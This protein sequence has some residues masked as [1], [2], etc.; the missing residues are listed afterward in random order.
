MIGHLPLAVFLTLGMVV[1]LGACV[2]SV[3]GFGLAVVAAPFVVVLEPHLMPAAL[4]VTSLALPS[5]EL[6]TGDRDI[7]WR[8]W[9]FAIGG[10]VLLM[11]V[12]VWL[13]T[14]APTSLI[15]VIVG[16]MVL[17]AV[18][19]S[20]SRIDVRPTPASSA[21]AGVITGVSGTAASIGGPFFAL[22]LQHERPSRIR[23]TLALF[24]VVGASSALTGLAVAGHVDATQ[25]KVGLAW[26]PFVLLG[27][28]IARPLRSRVDAAR[29]RRLVLALAT[30]AGVGVILL[31]VV[32]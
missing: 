26:I 15:A 16:A 32:S 13:V 11:P 9:C 8:P 18:A 30:V 2:Q 17:V 4:L 27:T 20:I 7:A 3:V 22:V 6:L 14:W 28:A 24:F 12:G 25:L 19:A 23:S 10:R 21:L 29:M 31:T 1:A 5:W